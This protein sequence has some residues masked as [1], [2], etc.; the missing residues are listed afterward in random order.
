MPYAV[1]LIIRKE[2]PLMSG[3]VVFMVEVIILLVVAAIAAVAGFAIGKLRTRSAM[4]AEVAKAREEVAAANA[5]L[6]A[7]RTFSA[8]ALKTQAETLRKEFQVMATQMARVEGQTLREEHLAR[9]NDLL[10]PLGK[11]IESFRTQF[12]SGHATMDRYIK[13]LVEQTT[14]V[15]HEAGQLAKALKANSKMQGNWGEAIL[16][17]LL[18]ASGLTE[19]RDYIVQEH[20]RDEEGRSLIPD[21][22]VNLPGERAVIVDSKVSLTAFADYAV[23]EDEDERQRLMRE[24][25]QSLRRHVKE[26][27]VKNYDKV[28]KNSIGYVLMFVPNEAAYIAAMNSDPKLA[29][30]AYAQRIIIVNPTNLLMAL[31]LAYNLWQ[32]ELQSR[33][34]FE[35]YNSAEKLYKKFSTFAQNFE[36]IGKSIRQLSTT[37][38]KAEKQLATGKG[39]IVDQLEGWKKKGLTPTSEIPESL[40]N[41]NENEEE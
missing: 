25:L 20:T 5:R 30:E 1:S 23:C 12:V 3:H 37:Y 33:S 7:E 24:H 19:G 36:Q 18:E 41:L 40:R 28:V 8:E 15:G 22:V 34:V 27:S 16:N 2:V 17:N 26:L 39:N 32:S 14:A 11:N 35:I 4:A 29:T 31:Q 13:D 38:E 6:S 9:L 10:A 21:V